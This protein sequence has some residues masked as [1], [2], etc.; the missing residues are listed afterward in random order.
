MTSTSS[1]EHKKTCRRCG[2]QHDASV[3]VCPECSE[4]LPE[5]SNETESNNEGAEQ[6]QHPQRRDSHHDS[7]VDSLSANNEV[8]E[9]AGSTSEQ[10][11]TAGV[12]GDP[13]FSNK[14]VGGILGKAAVRLFIF[15]VFLLGF[16]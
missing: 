16:W 10:P 6:T 8:R 1:G 7:S 5:A 4:V 14:L 11:S 12:S 13:N 9:T 15:P 3:M 2:R